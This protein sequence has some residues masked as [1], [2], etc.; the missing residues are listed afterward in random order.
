MD[1]QANLDLKSSSS[2]TIHKEGELTKTVEKVTAKIPSITFLNL[3]LASMAVS[4]G[5]AFLTNRK[6]LAN[7]IGLWAPSFLILGLYNKLVKVEGSDRT[8]HLH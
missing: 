2:D 6:G 8:E 1:P 4:A 7:F 5:F 3:A